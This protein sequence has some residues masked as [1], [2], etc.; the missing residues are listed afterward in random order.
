MNRSSFVAFL[1]VCFALVACGDNEPMVNPD[2]VGGAATGG[3]GAVGGSGGVAGTGGVAGQGGSSASGGTG[4][5]SG[6]GGSAGDGGA[7]GDG[8]S[9]ATGGSGAVG[10]SGGTGG[11]SGGGSGGSPPVCDPNDPPI[12]CAMTTTCNGLAACLPDGSAHGECTPPAEVCNDGVDNNCDGVADEGCSTS[13][14]CANQVG[15]II[16]YVFTT[17]Q[18]AV[19][20]NITLFDEALFANN[21]PMPRPNPCGGSQSDQYYAWGTGW[22]CGCNETCH[23]TYD[24]SVDCTVHRPLGAKLRIN[25]QMFS[26]GNPM[27]SSW[28]CTDIVG[29]LQNGA[30][31]IY[32]DGVQVGYSFIPDPDAAYPD[33]NCKVVVQI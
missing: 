30:L 25:I 16:R 8:G 11:S 29:A 22:D 17:P 15:R 26:M 2:F 5:S 14:G 13:V 10:G 31:Q 28:A 1:T 7:G 21:S 6:D 12:E 19:Y 33:P 3:S 32:V 20:A 18:S 24:N 27:T 9:A 23:A 4:G